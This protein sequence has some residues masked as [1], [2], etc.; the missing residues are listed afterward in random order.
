MNFTYLFSALTASVG[1]DIQPVR[2]L[3]SA[4]P[5]GSSVGDLSGSGRENRLAKQEP[6]VLVMH[7]FQSVNLNFSYDTS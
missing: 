6:T 4:I 1:N 7:K 2:K 3:A 5:I